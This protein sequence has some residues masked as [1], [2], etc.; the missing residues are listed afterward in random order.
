VWLKSNY[1]LQLKL[2]SIIRFQTQ[3]SV[4]EDRRNHRPKHVELI[5]IIN[6]PLLLHLVGCLYYF[7]SMMHGQKYQIL[8]NVLLRF[9]YQRHLNTRMVK[10]LWMMNCKWFG[11]DH[12]LS[13][14]YSGICPEG[15]RK[16]RDISVM[17]AN[18]LKEMRSRK[19]PNI[20]PMLYRHI[21]QC[22]IPSLSGNQGSYPIQQNPA[23]EIYP[24][25]E[26]RIH[27][28]YLKK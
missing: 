16:P 1:P 18:V 15:L 7:V 27:F 8:V 4:P 20:N 28:I 24:T 10:W 22:R 5:G 23:N 21:N 6:K 11:S 25:P 3:S 14:Y 9:V 13:R 12:G 17:T 2:Q 26:N 19:F